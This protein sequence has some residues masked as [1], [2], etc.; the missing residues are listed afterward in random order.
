MCIRDRYTTGF[1]QK[2]ESGLRRSV[3]SIVTQSRS[4]IT[5]AGTKVVPFGR[6][7]IDV[8]ADQKI[9]YFDQNSGARRSTALTWPDLTGSWPMLHQVLGMEE[10]MSSLV[11]SSHYSLRTEDQGPEGQPFDVRTKA[12]NWAPLLRW[13]SQFRN[14]IRLEA[15]TASARTEV[16]NAIQGNA[17]RTT[18]SVN[19]DVTLTKTYPAARGIRFPWSKRRVKLPNDVNLNLKMVLSRNK[20]ETMQPGLGSYLESETSRVQV[21]SGTSYNFTP[22]ITGGFDL[23]FE[24]NKDYKLDIT[25]RGIRMSVNGQ[26]R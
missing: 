26:F 21:G 6:L 2:F 15:N 16:L 8:H 17:T 10:M 20:A 24:Q 7:S 18:S 13:E 5:T 9:S 1:T 4:Y 3:T 25:R 11:V 22:S 12:T 14:G 23:S 19:H